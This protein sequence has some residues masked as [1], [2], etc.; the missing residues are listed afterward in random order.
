MIPELP[1]EGENVNP[2]NTGPETPPSKAHPNTEEAAM[3][4]A[5]DT[6][7]ARSFKPITESKL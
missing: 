5:P 4:I 6:R 2:E 1:H 3:D 7:L